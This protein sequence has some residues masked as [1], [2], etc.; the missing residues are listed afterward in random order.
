MSE[1]ASERELT[2]FSEAR[3]LP[4]AERVAYLDGACAGDAVSRQRVE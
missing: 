3:R 4:A 1:D 2:V